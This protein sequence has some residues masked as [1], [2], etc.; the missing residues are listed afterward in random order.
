MILGI[1]NLP[2]SSFFIETRQSI[3]SL[4]AILACYWVRL[5]VFGSSSAKNHLILTK[6]FCYPFLLTNEIMK[7]RLSKK[8][9]ISLITLSQKKNYCPNLGKK[10][11]L[12][13]TLKNDA[14]ITLLFLPHLE[15]PL[16]W[17]E[18]NSF[19]EYNPKKIQQLCTVSK[20]KVTNWRTDKGAPSQK[21]L[22]L[23]WSGPQP[24][25][26]DKIPQQRKDTCS[27]LS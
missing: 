17:T 6:S 16:V 14:L 26:C 5:P 13:F 20:D 23:S 21:V 4:P 19:V 27:Y 9:G 1:K 7:L 10:L 3:V 22:W 8:R 2:L 25:H 15:M 24:T 12:S 11:I 18:V